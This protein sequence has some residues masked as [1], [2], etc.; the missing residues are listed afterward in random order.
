VAVHNRLKSAT[1]DLHDEVESALDLNKMTTSVAAYSKTLGIL[2]TVFDC[3]HNELATIDFRPLEIDLESIER[4][5][6][7]LAADLRVLTAPFQNSESIRFE[8]PTS[9]HGFGCLY[10]LEGSALGGTVISKRV[11]QAL[12]LGPRTGCAYFH[13]LGRQTAGHWS[14]FLTALNTIPEN[15]AMGADAEAGAIATFLAF[16]QAISQF[17]DRKSV[18]TAPSRAKS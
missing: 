12:G 13:G 4:R 2:Y 9:G 10:V 3:A 14:E 5:R 6:N 17:G 18:P 11:E 15:S 16:R 7:W 8:L 1:A